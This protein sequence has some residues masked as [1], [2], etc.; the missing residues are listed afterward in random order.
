MCDVVRFV[1]FCCVV[2]VC[3]LCVR[4]VCNVCVRCLSCIVCWYIICCCA[5][6]CACMCLKRARVPFVMCCDVGWL[7]AVWVCLCVVVDECV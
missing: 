4:V 7:V 5:C 6:L 1:C 3:F 2:C